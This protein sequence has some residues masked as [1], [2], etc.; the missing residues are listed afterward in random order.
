MRNLLAF[1][2]ATSAAGV[3]SLA[4]C[5]QPVPPVGDLQ[6]ETLQTKITKSI[7]ADY[8]LFLPADYDK[9]KRDWPLVLFLHGAGERGDNVQMVKKEGL[10]KLL[11][12]G[13]QF[14]FILVA[15]QC[16]LDQGWDNDVLIALLDDVAARYRVDRDRICVTGLSMGGYG[17]WALAAA[18]PNRFAAIAPMC[19]GGSVRQVPSIAHVPA[20]VFHGARDNAVPLQESQDMVIGLRQFG[21]KVKFTVYPEASHDCWTAAYNTPALYD[22]MLQQRRKPAAAPAQ[23]VAVTRKAVEI[24]AES[25]TLKGAQVAGLLG[26]SGGKGVR[27]EAETDQAETKTHLPPGGYEVDVYMFCSD[28]DHDSI[29]LDVGSHTWNLWHNAYGRLAAAQRVMRFA[30]EEPAD[31]TVRFRRR[32]PGVI[33]D[34]IVFKPLY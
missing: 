3:L 22:W 33:V 4:G 5:P 10:P 9:D 19:G 21:G 18:C 16:P 8:L 32:E 23:R 31:V 6:A 30:L 2:A 24:E 14:P 13:K 17:T 34:R 7:K 25:F 28:G 27:F 1:V 26:A 15:P 20:W 29:A 11:A 12:A